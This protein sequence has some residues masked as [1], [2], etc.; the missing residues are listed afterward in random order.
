MAEELGKTQEEQ[1]AAVSYLQIR[2][3]LQSRDLFQ[4]RRG[5]LDFGAYANR[6][7]PRSQRKKASVNAVSIPTPKGVPVAQEDD[8]RPEGYDGP[9]PLKYTVPAGGSVPEAT[10]LAWRMA[11]R[12]EEMRR[13]A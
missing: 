12:Q 2:Q 1:W 8:D 3:I 9:M 7:A 5:T 10:A 4:V 11:K 6:G 13:D